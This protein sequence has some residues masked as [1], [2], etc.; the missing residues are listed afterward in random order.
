ML[1]L[2][3]ALS[4]WLLP[5]LALACPQCAARPSSGPLGTAALGAFLFLPFAAAG[6]VVKIIRA[7]ADDGAERSQDL[8]RPLQALGSTWQQD[9]QRRQAE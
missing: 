1:A 3:V 5:A 2:G 9:K 6:I 7:H 8:V 4:A